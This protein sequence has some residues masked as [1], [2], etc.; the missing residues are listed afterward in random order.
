MAKT[1]RP[2]SYCDETV[3]E[4]C[5]RL[6]LGQ[7]LTTICADES[8][9]GLTAVYEWLD[10]HED[11]AKRYARARSDQADTIFEMTQDV[12]EEEPGLDE[13]GKIDNGWVAKQRMRIDVLKWRAS[14]LKPKVYGD[15]VQQEHSGPDGGPIIVSTGV[16]TK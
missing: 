7:S 5:R 8:M 16:P 14:K 6:T 1:G 3:K 12:S 9:P 11:F 4:I 13:F 2:S 15:K 10:K